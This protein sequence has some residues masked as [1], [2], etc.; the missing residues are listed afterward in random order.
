MTYSKNH[1]QYLDDQE[2]KVW[3]AIKELVSLGRSAN[4]TQIARRTGLPTTRVYRVTQELYARG[5]L[6]DHGRGSA[7]HW[8]PTAKVAQCETV[9]ANG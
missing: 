2:M 8:R 7:Y 3:T 4:N 9:T 6:R 1:V 5:Y